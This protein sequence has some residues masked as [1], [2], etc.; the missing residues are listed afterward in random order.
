M[1]AS[2]AEEERERKT[3]TRRNAKRQTRNLL[4]HESDGVEEL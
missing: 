3:D 1:G 4:V 2:T